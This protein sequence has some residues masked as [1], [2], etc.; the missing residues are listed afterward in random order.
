MPTIYFDLDG[1]LAD[2]YNCPDWL[3]KLRAEDAQPYKDC[4]PLVDPVSFN[5]LLGHL[6]EQNYTLGVI[7][8]GSKGGS[9]AYT[10]EVKQAKREWVDEYFPVLRGCEFHVVKYGTPKHVTANS[11][12][13]ILV[14]D[15]KSVRDK[16]RNGATID[17]T[18]SA[19]M[20]K[21]LRELLL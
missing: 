8:W 21:S 6:Q 19:E 18:N 13:S 1:T 9:T 2:L 17:A 5:A 16:W 20:V 14:D 3:E 12:D 11:K 7:S 4:E 10:R 15:N